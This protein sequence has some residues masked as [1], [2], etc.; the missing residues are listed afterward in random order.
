MVERWAH[1]DNDEPEAR[2]TEGVS[3]PVESQTEMTQGML[4]IIT[5][6]QEDGCDDSFILALMQWY[7]SRGGRG[8]QGQGSSGPSGQ[9]RGVTPSQAGGGKRDPKDNK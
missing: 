8:K 5:N 2:T 3:L 7:Q 6:M 1:H 9:R 4:A